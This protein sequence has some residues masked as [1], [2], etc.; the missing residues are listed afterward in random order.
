MQIARS[1]V[2]RKGLGDLVRKP[3]LH[4]VVG[5]I[6][7]DDPSSMMIKYNHGVTHS[8]NIA[9]AT[10]N[11]PTAAMSV[12]W[13]RGKLLQVGEGALGRRGRCLPIVAGLTSMPSLGS[14]RA[15]LAWDSARIPPRR[16]N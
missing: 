15:S 3:D 2:L 12:M 16:I 9:V 14:A 5:H 1:R 10:T 11:M 4:R 13:F 6:E 8:L 7:I